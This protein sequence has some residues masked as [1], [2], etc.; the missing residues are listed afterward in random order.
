MFN[1]T[2]QVLDFACADFGLGIGQGRSAAQPELRRGQPSAGVLLGL[3]DF[4]R[5]AHQAGETHNPVGFG[6]SQPAAGLPAMERRFRDAQQGDELFHR[7]GQTGLQ[8][9]QL[10]NRESDAEDFD[11]FGWGEIR[12]RDFGGWAMH[13]EVDHVAGFIAP[14]AGG[15]CLGRPPCRRVSSAVALSMYRSFDTFD[16][17]TCNRCQLSHQEALPSAPIMTVTADAKLSAPGRWRKVQSLAKEAGVSLDLRQIKGRGDEA[18]DFLK[19]QV[20]QPSWPENA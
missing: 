14:P 7:H 17:L 20:I 11:Q 8:V 16:S 9:V 1:T 10:P 3:Q 15:F 5:L 12:C 13:A 4:D 6:R 2:E 18:A 19:Q